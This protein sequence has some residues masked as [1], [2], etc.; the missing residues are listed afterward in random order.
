MFKVLKNANISISDEIRRSA[1]D[2]LCSQN[3]D[4]VELFINKCESYQ[5]IVQALKILP[6]PIAN[7]ILHHIATLQPFQIKNE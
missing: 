3:I 1:L 6:I 2:W 5:Q 4:E 7:E